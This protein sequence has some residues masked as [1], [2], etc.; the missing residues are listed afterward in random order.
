MTDVLSKLITM[1]E[2]IEQAKKTGHTVE[3]LQSRYWE[4]VKEAEEEFPPDGPPIYLH[5]KPQRGRPKNGESVKPAKTKSVKMPPA[6]WDDFQG[7]AS[8]EGLTLHS[9]MRAALVEW[10]EKRHV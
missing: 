8:N 7:I 9:A 3:E 2:A 1:E 5:L 10:A 6:F 4:S